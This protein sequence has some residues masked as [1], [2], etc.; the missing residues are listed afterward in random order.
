MFKCKS[1]N[2]DYL[3]Y[4]PEDQTLEVCFVNGGV[5]HYYNVT[6]PAYK[7]FEEADSHGT[8]FAKH[9]KNAFKF[10]KQEKKEKEKK[11]E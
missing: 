2:I 3:K 1:S 10:K 6:Q 4:N 7:A 8:H 5:Y 11:D 9:V